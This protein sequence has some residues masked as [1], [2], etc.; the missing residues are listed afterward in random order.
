MYNK[1]TT[2]EMKPRNLRSVLTSANMARRDG[3]S[4]NEKRKTSQVR[5]ALF[6]DTHWGGDLHSKKE[7][8]RL[9]ELPTG[10]SDTAVKNILRNFSSGRGCAHL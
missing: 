9:P 6:T 5:T 8:Q 3:L 2:D 10:H 4:A 7:L 1:N